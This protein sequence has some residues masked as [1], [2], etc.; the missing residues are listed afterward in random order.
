VRK[1]AKKTTH[2]KKKMSLFNTNK[3]AR[4]NNLEK[5]YLSLVSNLDKLNNANNECQQELHMRNLIKKYSNNTLDYYSSTTDEDDTY[6]DQDSDSFSFTLLPRELRT[7]TNYN[8]RNLSYLNGTTED[9]IDLLITKASKEK[10]DEKKVAV[11]TKPPEATVTASRISLL[12]SYFNKK[13]TYMLEN[14]PIKPLD[15]QSKRYLLWLSIVSIAYV[16]NIISIS[17]RYSFDIDYD[18]SSDVGNR[19]ENLNGYLNE[20]SQSNQSVS[21]Q[22]YENTSLNS[23]YRNIYWIICDYLADIVYLVDMVL[24]QTRIKFV[25]EGLWVSDIKATALNYFKSSNII[26]NIF[27]LRQ[28]SNLKNNSRPKK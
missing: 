6:Y 1:K 14:G 19:S 21:A 8:L 28:K 23:V 7:Q 18:I 16:Y 15:S 24:I 22:N 17:L 20:S 13:A 27:F 12:V 11:E 10:Q 25:K 9:C 4:E 3:K 2:T 5:K 26:V